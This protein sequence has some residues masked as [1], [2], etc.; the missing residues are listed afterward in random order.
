MALLRYYQ[1]L[2]SEAMRTTDGCLV[3]PAHD[4][5]SCSTGTAG[6]RM[7]TIGLW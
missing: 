6:V 7:K 4:L 5:F 3:D 2:A 1:L